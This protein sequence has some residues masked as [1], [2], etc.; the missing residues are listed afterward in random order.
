MPNNIEDCQKLIAILTVN[1]LQV[2]QQYN[3]LWSKGL[4]ENE[5]GHACMTAGERAIETLEHLGIVSDC[6][7]FAEIKE[8][9]LS[10]YKKGIYE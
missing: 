4:S 1:L 7:W 5:V 10:S 3:T 8:P 2:W 9:F 6:G